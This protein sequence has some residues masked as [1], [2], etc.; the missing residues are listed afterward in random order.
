[1]TQYSEN[2]EL[3]LAYE[4]VRNTGKN[5]FLTG[6]AGTGKTTFLH[7]LKSESPKRMIVVAPTGVAA[8]NA[9]GVTI[10]SF[11]QLSFAP[12]I[13]SSDDDPFRYAVKGSVTA[14]KN[15]NKEKINIIKGLDLLVI[16]EIS[17]VR[18]DLLDAVD[19]VLRRYRD[20][21][22]PFGG[23]QLLL[24]G[25]MNQ[26]PPVVTNDD[27]TILKDHYDTAYFFGS[28]A[29][30]KS[31]F[32]SIELK[33]IYRQSDKKFVH[34]LNKIRENDIDKEV[35]DALN[36]RFIPNFVPDAGDSYITLTA[37]NGSA[38][39]INDKE[40][41]LLQ[42]P[43][44][45]FQASISD[46]FP[47]YSFPT[48]KELQLKEG[49]QVMFV[50]NDLSREKLYYNGKIGTITR[51]D[52]DEIF[53]KCTGDMVEIS[54]KRIVWEN[55]KYQVHAETKEIEESVVGTFTQFPLKLAWAI[56]IHKSQGLTFEKM[57][58]DAAHS[59]AHGQVYV[60]LSRCR[61]L[62]GIVL[63]S[64]L[65]KNSVICDTNISNFNKQIADKHVTNKELERDRAKYQLTLMQEL[66]RFDAFLSSLY[67]ILK[68]SKENQSIITPDV[69]LI[70]SKI[71]NYLKEQV[72]E[73]AVKFQQQLNYI[74]DQP[75]VD[76][77]NLNDRISKASVWFFSKLTS[78][79]VL[80]ANAL[81]FHCDNKLIR[82][83]LS[84]ALTLFRQELNVKLKCFDICRNG[85]N[86]QK[87]LIVRA[88]AQLSVKDVL[89]K[90]QT[91][92]TNT[93][94]ETSAHPE[95]FNLLKEWRTKKAEELESKPYLILHQKALLSLINKMPLNLNDLKSI[96]G[97]GLV[98]SKTF[99]A[100][101]ISIIKKYVE[102]K[103][104]DVA[105][106]IKQDTSEVI[107]DATVETKEMSYILFRKGFTPSEI[108]LNR[109]LKEGTIHSHLNFY[110]LHGE[111]FID[112][113]LAKEKIKILSEYYAV[114]PMETISKAK[115]DL[116]DGIS[117]D[118]IRYFINYLKYSRTM[119]T[120][121]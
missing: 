76:H 19:A 117:Y 4:Y 71:N 113:L 103:K 7:R 120:V 69:Y 53:V 86:I 90:E 10:H 43:V 85:L 45:T 91:A 67:H 11:F 42:H 116:G 56:T 119:D 74:F 29:L 105:S 8:I 46:E 52:N 50:R 32:I 28:K 65:G 89:E 14:L 95:L 33:H 77:S 44:H 6:K 22:L 100:E 25:D 48:D 17:M 24:I 60:A 110:V 99:G 108:A 84:D 83:S 41:N 101:L 36:E 106:E 118:D 5:I 3:H 27:W 97:I 12:F 31:E 112:E 98:K 54:V 20:K 21:S 78:D 63:I 16:D 35:T 40:L 87:Y 55:I 47:D 37:H 114:N 81:E 121:A 2:P 39:N 68:I 73:V 111:I 61:T 72:Q 82:K 94:T 88:T 109:N 66:F 80:E 38:R 64:R 59:F 70:F 51:I 9:R 30:R 92:K 15:F 57:M 75:V 58:I 107:A 104:I 1:M 13:P 18:A 93:K 49:A 96:H 23:T 26:L 62:E 34:I 102:E 115:Q 79:L